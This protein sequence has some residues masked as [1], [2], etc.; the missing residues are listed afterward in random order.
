MAI[1]SAD[2]LLKYIPAVGIEIVFQ[3][4]LLVFKKKTS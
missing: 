2:I 4:P 3:N 1:S